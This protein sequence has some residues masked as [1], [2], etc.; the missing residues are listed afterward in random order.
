MGFRCYMLCR[1]GAKI[2][3]DKLKRPKEGKRD[4]RKFSGTLFYDSC[5]FFLFLLLFSFPLHACEREGLEENGKCKNIKD[6]GNYSVRD[7]STTFAVFSYLPTD[8]YHLCLPYNFNRTSRNCKSLWE[9]QTKIRTTPSSR[10]LAS[11]NLT[12]SSLKNPWN[13]RMLRSA[14]SV[15]NIKINI[16]CVT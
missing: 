11:L 14:R 1:E 9:S 7:F 4:T 16:L 13:K 6:G 12:I 3:L 2:I 5:K 8:S 15:E 10:S